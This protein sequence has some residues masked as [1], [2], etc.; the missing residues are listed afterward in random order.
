MSAAENATCDNGDLRLAGG[1]DEHAGILE[2]C[3]N[4]YWGTVCDD[5]WTSIDTRTVCDILGYNDTRCELLLHTS[6]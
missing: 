1:N 4:G 6:A 3:F 2:V 5:R